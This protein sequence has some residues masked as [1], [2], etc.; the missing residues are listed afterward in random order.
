VKAEQQ[1]DPDNNPEVMVQVIDTGPG[2]APEDQAKLFQPFSQVDGSLTRR[3]GGSGL[4]LSI[5]QALVQLHGGKIGLRS[6]SGKGSTF[7]FTL[8]V[9]RPEGLATVIPESQSKA[10]DWGT[11]PLAYSPKYSAYLPEILNERIN[12]KPSSFEI[13]DQDIAEPSVILAIDPDDQ[14]IGLYRRYLA[15]QK[16]SVT[17]LSELGKAVDQV[18]ETQP[19]AVLLDVTMKSPPDDQYRAGLDGW[20]VLQELKSNPNT[21]HIPII[22][23]SIQVDPEKAFRTGATDYLLKPILEEDLVQVVQ[24]LRKGIDRQ[25]NTV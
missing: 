4:G 22:I 2:I 25:R 19:F 16:C 13:A 1:N 23:C 18:R 3:T 17:G 15:G 11:A 7:Y 9:N 6:L 14:V 5:C 10:L 20:R 12:G 8:P 21:K 24:G